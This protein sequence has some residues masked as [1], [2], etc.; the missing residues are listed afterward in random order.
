MY[1]NK[2]AHHP[3]R[4]GRMKHFVSDATKL[5]TVHTY[6]QDNNRRASFLFSIFAQQHKYTPTSVPRCKACP[7]TS[8][9][10][11]VS[12]RKTLARRRRCTSLRPTESF[13][14]DAECLHDRDVG[15]CFFVLEER[16]LLV[17]RLSAASSVFL[18]VTLESAPFAE[19][20]P[21]LAFDGIRSTRRLCRGFV[22]T[23]S[24]RHGSLF[25]SLLLWEMFDRRSS[26][27][28]RQSSPVAS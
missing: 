1:L 19:V 26:S 27:S 12:T 13:S 17:E 11:V 20:V 4:K 2:A 23:Q 14:S 3:K 5:G 10:P 18:E 15:T 8:S 24:H 16:A 25:S 28:L 6:I 7:P 9:A 22:S 21:Q